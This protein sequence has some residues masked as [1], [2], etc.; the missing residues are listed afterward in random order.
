MDHLCLLPDIF[1][2]EL[3]FLPVCSQ[4]FQENNQVDDCRRSIPSCSDAVSGI[5]RVYCGKS[6]RH[7]IHY[8]YTYIYS[9]EH[10]D[11]HILPQGMGQVQQGGE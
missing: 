11:V 7:H 5:H 3:H 2:D 9:K 10:V 4:Q 8:A 6:S 1:M